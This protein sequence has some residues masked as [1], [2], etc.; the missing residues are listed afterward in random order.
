MNTYT[1]ARPEVHY[2][3]D[4]KVEHS[5]TLKEEPRKSFESTSA[6]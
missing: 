6:E 5:A 1:L 3:L 2:D 4:S